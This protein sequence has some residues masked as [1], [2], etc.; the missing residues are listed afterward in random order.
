[1]YI[2]VWEC[3]HICAGMQVPAEFRR[4]HLVLWSWCD[5]YLYTVKCECWEDTSN[6]L[7][8]QYLLLSTEP[9]LQF[10][11]F[12]LIYGIY[13]NVHNIW[14]C[15]L[16]SIYFAYSFLCRETLDLFLP[17]RSCVQSCNKHECPYL[18]PCYQF[19]GYLPSGVAKSF[20]NTVFNFR[21]NIPVSFGNSVF[22]LC[23]RSMAFWTQAQSQEHLW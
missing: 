2:C 15:L 18:S 17:F 1:M 10:T 7:L 14:F 13:R 23:H 12:S 3:G 11:S 19:F 21:R 4:G 20:D 6:P 16:D 9:F 22:C 5:K 8:E